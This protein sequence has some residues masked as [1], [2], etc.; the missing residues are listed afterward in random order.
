[1]DVKDIKGTSPRKIFNGAPK[2]LM[3]KYSEVFGAKSRRARIRNDYNYMNYDDV[4]GRRGKNP[5]VALEDK[6]SSLSALRNF[7]N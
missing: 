7:T 1:M 6:K 5:L 2:P 4:V 3:E